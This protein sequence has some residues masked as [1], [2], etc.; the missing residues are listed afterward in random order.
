MTLVRKSIRRTI[1]GCIWAFGA[2]CMIDDPRLG[3][4][5]LLVLIALGSLT[6]RPR[7]GIK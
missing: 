5:A 7:K 6:Y 3:A 1:L 2:F 4:G